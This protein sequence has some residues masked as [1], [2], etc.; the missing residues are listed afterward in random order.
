[1]LV[2]NDF[3]APALDS[4]DD[5]LLNG[6]GIELRMLRLDEIHPQISGNK[7]YKLKH[8]LLAARAQSHNTVLSFGGA[9]SNH[10][11]ALAAAS[12]ACALQSIGI[13]RG[14]APS[15]LNPALEFVQSQGMALHFIS[16]SDYRHKEDPVFI[17]ELEQR[18]GSFYMIPEGGSN[19]LGI[20]GCMEIAAHLRWS[21][22]PAPRFVFMA[23]GTA[24][25]LTG[26]VSAVSPGCEVVGVSVLKGRDTLSEQVSAWLHMLA[27]KPAVQWSI[28]T[29]FHHGGYGKTS[30]ELTSFIEA[31]EE[32]TGIPLEPIYTGKMMWGLYQMIESGEIGR[33]A[34]IIALHTGGLTR[35]I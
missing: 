15:Q 32:R 13:I 26:V 30:A 17:N 10:L 14:E 1:M 35:K 33:G 28:K 29:G 23:C 21:H 25:T 16:R 3:K 4:V 8:N 34:Q 12:N 2:D 20:K 22:D 11:V 5:P 19:L 31:F 7:W 24:A 9:Y 27:S 6:L 18:F